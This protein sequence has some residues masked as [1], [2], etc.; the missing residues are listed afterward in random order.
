MKKR[1]VTAAVMCWMI[2]IFLF[3]AKPAD[4]SEEMSLSVGKIIGRFFVSS[5]PEWTAEEQQ[6]FAEKIDYPVR[7]SAHASE[8]AVLGVLVME[9]LGTYGSKGGARLLLSQG[10]G[11]L[12]AASDEFHQLFVPGRSGQVTDVMLDSAGVLAGILIFGL[13]ENWLRRRNSRRIGKN[14]QTKY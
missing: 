9:M 13:A 5:Y 6:K 2:V 3:S 1:I 7:K 8:Y 10:I 11:T 12:Y 14:E 4:E